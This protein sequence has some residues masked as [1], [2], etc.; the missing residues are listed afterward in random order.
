[1]NIYIIPELE[2]EFKQFV[3][4]RHGKLSKLGEEMEKA[5]SFYMNKERTH[6]KI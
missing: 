2:K 6:A 4:S 3:L 1:M 5:L